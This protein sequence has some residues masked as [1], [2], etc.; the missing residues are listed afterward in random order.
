MSRHGAISNENSSSS[1]RTVANVTVRNIRV[2]AAA[3]NV[4]ITGTVR[5]PR[6]LAQ[7]QGL[8]F[9]KGYV[10]PY[11]K[12]GTVLYAPRSHQIVTAAAQLCR[13]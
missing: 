8:P 3:N 4:D 12:D 9:L 5:N 10:G 13:L 11:W 6:R 2:W 7:V 1:S